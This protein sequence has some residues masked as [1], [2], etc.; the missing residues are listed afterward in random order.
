MSSA[1]KWSPAT[2]RIILVICLILVGLAVWQFSVVLSPLVVAVIIAYLLNSPVNWLTRRTPLSRGLAAALVYIGFLLLLAMIPTLAA[3]LVIQQVRQIDFDIQKFTDNLTEAMDYRVSVGGLPVNLNLLIEPVTGSLGEMFS[4]LASWAADIAVGIAGGFIWAIF[5]FVVGF[6]LLLDADR[7]SDWLDS[8][9]P[10]DY[11]EEF[12]ALRREIGNVWRSYFIGQMTLALIV[13]VIIGGATA[14]LGIRSAF[15]LGVVAALLELIPN[16]GYSI[17]G[18]IGIMFAY[19][20]GSTYIPLPNWAFALLVGGFYF[21]MWQIDT[22]YLVPR[23][24]GHRLRLSPAVVIV[25]IIA[26]ASVGG[27]LGLL[28]AA[29]TIATIRVLGS[30]LYRRLLDL[31]PYVLVETPPAPDTANKEPQES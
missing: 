30:Y 10:P 4:P 22:N 3:P 18:F 16:W 11:A 9:I 15:L 17:S 24:I 12:T 13:G 28:L 31:E 14:L 27:A 21:L 23:I 8:W 25:G 6:Y 20:Q 2:K 19:F 5:I 26:G 29:P 7:F 1:P